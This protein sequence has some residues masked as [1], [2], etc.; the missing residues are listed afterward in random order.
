M[1][2][3][4]EDL[5]A[6]W[7]ELAEG[8]VPVIVTEDANWTSRDLVERRRGEIRDQIEAWERA[9]ESLDTPRYAKFYSEDFRTETKS[10]RAWLQHKTRVNAAKQFIDIDLNGLSIL[11]Y[12]GEDDLVVASFTQDYRSSN[13]SSLGR[14]TSVLERELD[15]AWRIVY[16]GT[17]R[18]RPEHVRGIP[19]SARSSLTS[20]SP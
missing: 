18:I 1:A 14:Q 9:W 3:A 2:L 6:I 7:G 8:G 10:L 11:G 5:A 13:F 15:G 17:V 19:Y 12:P 20:V 4:N 16:E